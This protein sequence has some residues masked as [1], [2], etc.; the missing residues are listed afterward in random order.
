M[1]S[2]MRIVKRSTILIEDLSNDSV[3]YC[4]CETAGNKTML[5]HGMAINM[6][7]LEREEEKQKVK[8][9]NRQ[10]I[11]STIGLLLLLLLLLSLLLLLLL[12]LLLLSII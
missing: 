2:S 8:V 4:A 10:L 9:T 7:T 5:I 12:Q 11:I 6:Y 1:R 3:S